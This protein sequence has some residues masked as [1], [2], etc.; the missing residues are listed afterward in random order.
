MKQEA[1][2]L[3]DR[4]MLP[5]RQRQIFLALAEARSFLSADQLADRVY[6]DDPD[7]GPLDAR[8]CTYAFLNRLRRSVAP[9]GVSIITSR[10]LGYRLEMPP[11][12]EGH[13]G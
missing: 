2:E 13:H 1:I 3:A 5:R 4:I 8:A 11:R 6:S 10:H 7:G 12:A 9:H